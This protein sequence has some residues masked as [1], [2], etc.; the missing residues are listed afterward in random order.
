M[1]NLGILISGR[2][3]NMESILKSI[4]RKKIPINPAIVISN[5]QDARGLEIARKLGIKTEV[6]ESKDFKGSRWEYDKKIISVLE[7]HG[8]T[9]K[10]GL[11]CLAG[12]MRIISPEFVKKY[13]NRIINIHPA[14]LP[15]FPGLDAQKQAIE[16][17]SKY[18]GC[19]VHFVDSGVDTGPIILQSVVKIKKGDTEKTL[20]KR[21]LAKEHQAYPEAIRLFAEKKIK[22]SGRKTIID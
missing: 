8:V 7:K 2:G 13:K 19:T 15:A 3:S 11:V 22:I 4:K 1:L 9:P 10:N 12:F 6:I 20:S 16:Y 17:G 18:S 5:K 14:L 21:I